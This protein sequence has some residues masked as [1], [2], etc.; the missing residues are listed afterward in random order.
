[1]KKN[2]EFH[3]KILR[4][5]GFYVLQNLTSFNSLN[6]SV[7]HTLDLCSCVLTTCSVVGEH[8]FCIRQVP[9]SSPVW[10]NNSFFMLFQC[11]WISGVQILV[12]IVIFSTVFNSHG[13][14]GKKFSIKHTLGCTRC[15]QA[16]SGGNRSKINFC[17]LLF[18][19]KIQNFELFK[20][21][22]FDF[23]H[24]LRGSSPHVW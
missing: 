14:Y 17:I 19:K 4:K 21:P 20:S 23:A 6:Q 10:A 8:Y 5:R 13:T 7:L 15:L 11:F 22:S 12:K 3:E 9:G 18:N 16:E 24:I 2:S 1:M